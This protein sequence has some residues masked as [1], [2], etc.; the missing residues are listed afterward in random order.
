[1][2]LA[3]SYNSAK[4]HISV[5]E[6]VCFAEYYCK[7]LIYLI[8]VFLPCSLITMQRYYLFFYLPNFCNTFFVEC[9]FFCAPD[10][11]IGL[12]N[13]LELDNNVIRV[14]FCQIF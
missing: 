1:M 4:V 11:Y 10:F 8:K 2:Q 5:E 14:I 6:L 9:V 13:S 3:K 7:I 12:H